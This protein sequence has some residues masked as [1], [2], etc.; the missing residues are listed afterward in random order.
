MSAHDRIESSTNLVK[1]F[2]IPPGKIIVILKFGK[3]SEFF[4][5]LFMEEIC[6]Y[7]TCELPLS[8]FHHVNYF[9]PHSI[10]GKAKPLINVINKSH[11]FIVQTGF[12]LTEALRPLGLFFF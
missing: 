10:N 7:S 3:I 8:D 1:F 12:A 2:I 5:Q 9:I 4:T 6:Q 11:K